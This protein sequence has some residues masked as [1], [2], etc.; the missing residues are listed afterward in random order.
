MA[1]L[2]ALFQQYHILNIICQQLRLGDFRALAQTESDIRLQLKTVE[3][4]AQRNSPYS[5]RWIRRPCT[6]TDGPF[7]YCLMHGTPILRN[8]AR[9][10]DLA[11]QKPQ[12]VDIHYLQDDLSRTWM[13]TTC[14]ALGDQSNSN[15]CR[16]CHASVCFSYWWTDEIATHLNTSDNGHALAACM[17]SSIPSICPRNPTRI[18]SSI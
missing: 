14:D 6:C 15:A 3:R 7:S 1:S 17:L 10:T 12:H 2:F 13:A 11:C 8:L 16:M 18:S 5:F 9:K 4:P